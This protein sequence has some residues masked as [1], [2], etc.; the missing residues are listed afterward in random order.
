MF[1]FLAKRLNIRNNEFS[2]NGQVCP[3]SNIIRNVFDFALM[4]GLLSSFPPP[5][6]SLSSQ[7]SSAQL[8]ELVCGNRCGVT[9]DVLALSLWLVKPQLRLRRITT[10]RPLWRIYM[11]RLVTYC[12]VRRQIT[13]HPL[14]TSRAHQRVTAADV[15]G[16]PGVTAADVTG[17][18]H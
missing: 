1:L 6:S 8:V 5:S 12:D 4:L 7:S 9:S 3:I 13:E 16:T 14:L 10:I 18:H 11:A 2:V 15:T 17:T